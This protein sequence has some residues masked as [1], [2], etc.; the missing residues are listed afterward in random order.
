M[1]TMVRLVR[2]GPSQ[3]V[4]PLVS[5]LRR[6]AARYSRAMGHPVGRR[7]GWISYGVFCL[8]LLV[9]HFVIW[10]TGWPLFSGRG[11]AIWLLAV[12][13]SLVA[14]ELGYRLV[15]RPALRLLSKLSRT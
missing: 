9:L 3:W 13:L 8:H 14:A 11:I 6:N 7:L 15:E 12:G 5:G 4:K 2:P 10:A 1:S